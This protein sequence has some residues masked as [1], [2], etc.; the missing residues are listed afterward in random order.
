MPFNLCLFIATNIQLDFLNHQIF[1]II[2]LK[3][4]KN[5]SMILINNYFRKG[6]F[7]EI[8]HQIQSLRSIEREFSVA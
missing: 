4:I 7:L 1:P 8:G 5:D 3:K 2:F 6:K